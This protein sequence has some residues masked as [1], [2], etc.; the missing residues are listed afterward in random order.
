MDRDS[1]RAALD[2]WI[3]A[4]VIN[5]ETA[6]RIREFERA[7][8]VPETDDDTAEADDAGDASADRGRGLLE[9]NRVVVALALMGGVLVAVG[10]GA[11]LYER[12]ESIPIVA[13]VAILV[14]VPLVAAAGGTRLREDSP[15]TAHG[16]WL[17]AALFTGVTL[18]RLAELT[19]V[20]DVDAAR[21]WLLAAWTAV[22]VAI[23]AGLDSRPIGGAGAILGAATLASATDPAE[24]VLLFGAYGGLLYVAGLTTD[25]SPALPRFAATLR[26]IG[27]A[28]A[29]AALVPVVAVGSPPEG[30]SA[31][32]VLLVAASVV[33]AAVAVGHAGDDRLARYA[34]APAVAAPV[35]AAVAWGI[36][37]HVGDFAGSLVALG[38]LL[39]VVLALVVGAVGL[40]EAAPANV[41][42]LGFVLGVVA[43][44]AGPVGD[45]I[46]GSLALVVA[47]AVLLA[48][49]LGAERGRRA[50][51]AR[52]G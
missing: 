13:R 51:L 15:R 24:F 33:A 7:D 40:R 29:A 41:A 14:G 31:G 47:G 37:R 45:A 19:T 21:A 20:V 18:F 2:R 4:G 23:G 27:G 11:Y 38:C 35:A 10:V 30:L 8:E 6:S 22:A 5:E 52:I 17:L 39:G 12:W 16:L 50:V 34:T 36:P 3:D 9:E 49:G 26:W 46:S 42:A 43:F 48:A 28:F 44:V 32:T 25:E 1:L